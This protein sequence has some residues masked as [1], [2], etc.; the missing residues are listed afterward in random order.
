MNKRLDI[1]QQTLE[2]S[3]DAAGNPANANNAVPE[4]HVVFDGARRGR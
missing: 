2:K 4:I 3:D 1:G